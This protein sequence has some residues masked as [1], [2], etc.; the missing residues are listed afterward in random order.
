M[1][2][3]DQRDAC[4]DERAAQ[5][6]RA[7]HSPEEHPVLVFGGN[8]E[9]AKEQHEDEEV[10]DR[11]RLLQQVAGKELQALLAAVAEPDEASKADGE[12]NPEQAPAQRFLEAA[13]RFLFPG[14]VEVDGEEHQDAR[15]K[16][17][18]E[19]GRA[20]VRRVVVGPV[21]HASPDPRGWLRLFSRKTSRTGTRSLKRSRN[22]LSR[23][24]L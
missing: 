16:S 24:R 20:D 3:M 21:G 11:E 23:K 18:P 15:Q 1:K 17:A 6:Q 5:D 10:V 12:R 4:D 19:R 9:A 14:N 13:L 8:G 2:A 7:Q 22:R